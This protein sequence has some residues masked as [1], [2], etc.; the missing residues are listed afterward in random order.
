MLY[1]TE[2][3]LR[4]VSLHKLFIV[5]LKFNSL[6]CS[7]TE[8]TNDRRT[9]HHHS[10]KLI[11]LLDEESYGRTDFRFNSNMNYYLFVYH[12]LVYLPRG[13]KRKFRLIIKSQPGK[14]VDRWKLILNQIQL[15]RKSYIWSRPTGS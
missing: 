13:D 4:T 5:T 14:R 3:L 12:N 11:N 8:D 10:F 15:L 1:Y 6:S 7:K 2:V 9:S